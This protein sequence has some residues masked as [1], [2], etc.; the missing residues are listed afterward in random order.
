[1]SIFFN[2]FNDDRI[3]LREKSKGTDIID[4]QTS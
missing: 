4:K 2:I 1:M 3:T